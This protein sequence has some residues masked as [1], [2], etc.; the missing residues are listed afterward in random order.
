MEENQPRSHYDLWM[1]SGM[2]ATR[3]S[4]RVYET[5]AEAP[6]YPTLHQQLNDRVQRKSLHMGALESAGTRILGPAVVLNAPR[7]MLDV[8]VRFPLRLVRGRSG[9]MRGRHFPRISL[10]WELRGVGAE[11][12]TKTSRLQPF[13]IWC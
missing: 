12:T 6:W 13:G 10:I 5:L 1:I 8:L 4:S 3:L 7:R 2:V 11:G 9:M